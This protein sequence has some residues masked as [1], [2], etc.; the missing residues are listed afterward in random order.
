MDRDRQAVL[1][2]FERRKRARQIN[3]LTDDEEVNLNLR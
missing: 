1:E 2:E 3:V